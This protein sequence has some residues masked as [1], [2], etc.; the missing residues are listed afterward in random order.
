MK[1]GEPLP[2]KGQKKFNAG[3]S[4]R[5][6]AS[7]SINFKLWEGDI[8]DPVSDNRPIGRFCINGQDFEEGVISAGTE[9]I[10]EYEVLDSGNIVL[11]VTVP[12]IGGTFHSGRNFYSRQADQIDYTSASMRVHEDAESVRSRIE[13]VA[14]QV[15]SEKLD[16]ARGKLDQ[17]SQIE[18]GESDPETTKQAMDN[19]LEAKKLLAQV[20]KEHQ[21]EIRQL[22]LDHCAAFFR[23]RVREFA[24]PTEATSFENLVRTAQTSIR[25][26]SADF[27]SH[28]GQLK[29]KNFEV[30]W[31]Q[32]WFV[33]DWF[34]R[35]A[36]ES[37]LFTDKRRYVELI[38]AGAE[39]VKA[40]DIDGLR[41]VVF[42]LD[43]LKIGVGSEDDMFVAANIVRG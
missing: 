5:A 2:K 35:L 33:V 26:N 24:R 27:E 31:R 40:D 11:E 39:M 38:A 34:K 32:D 17:A 43:S 36:E 25:N 13:A 9:L 30:L 22:D 29:T 19:V 21:K 14:G 12:S 7:G 28:L 10:C 18:P 15:D 16:Q 42:E 20:R 4:L 41:R 8:E 1:E 23:E 3:E 37:Y 6:R